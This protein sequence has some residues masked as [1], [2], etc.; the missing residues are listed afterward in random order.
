MNI[1][2]LMNVFVMYSK[3]DLVLCVPVLGSCFGTQTPIHKHYEAALY[4]VLCVLTTSSICGL[5]FS[6]RVHSMGPVK[7]QRG[8]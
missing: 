3:S 1:P 8:Q 5:K 7:L 6:V 4:T 2:T